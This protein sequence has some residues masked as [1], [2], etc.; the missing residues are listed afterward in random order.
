MN[1]QTVKNTLYEL[2][3]GDEA[4][5]ATLGALDEKLQAF[6]SAMRAGQA[7]VV[8]G[9]RQVDAAV[10]GPG[11]NA[12]EETATPP[13]D[14]SADAPAIEA[15][16]AISEPEATAAPDSQ[17]E[18]EADDESESADSAIEA[19][20]DDPDE[21]LG[22]VLDDVLDEAVALFQSPVL[23]EEAPA[24]AP[25]SSQEEEDALLA[26]LDTETATLIRVKRRL[27]S[28]PRSVRELLDEVRAEQSRA[29]GEKKETS[30]WWR[31]K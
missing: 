12:A 16:E 31:R 1:E 19:A 15:P 4:I 6:L 2:R 24:P 3:E 28:T 14:A 27:S 26:S 9:L 20:V 30:R 5:A 10:T 13:A 7:T 22:D 11:R 8:A 21:M 29:E 25:I 18:P 23:P 17:I